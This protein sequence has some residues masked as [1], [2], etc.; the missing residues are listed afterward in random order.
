MAIPKNKNFSDYDNYQTDS[1]PTTAAQAQDFFRNQ[2][3]LLKAVVDSGCWQPETNYALD[4]VVYSP[5]FPKSAEA[6]CI[7]AGKSSSTEPSWGEIG[8]ADI[9]DG[10]AI[11]KLFPKQ[12]RDEWRD[13][14]A[15]EAEAL[16]GETDDK[17]MTPKKVASMVNESLGFFQEMLW[18]GHLPISAGGTGASDAKTA[19]ENLGL[20]TAVIGVEY[21]SITKKLIFSLANGQEL[22]VQIK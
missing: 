22:R 3:E 18:I 2:A 12:K 14:I 19:V 15:T 1:N 10:T 11:W 16:A 6:V 17:I 21:D 9:L 8:G 7:K 4:D 20:G 13:A 5:S